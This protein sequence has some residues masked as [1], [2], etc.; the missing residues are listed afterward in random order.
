MRR[1]LLLMA[2]VTLK[3]LKC[4]WSVCLFKVSG[5]QMFSHKHPWTLVTLVF[6]YF[7]WSVS[8]LLMIG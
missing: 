2:Y 5:Q 7:F 3:L 1:R 4:V 8:V 6:A